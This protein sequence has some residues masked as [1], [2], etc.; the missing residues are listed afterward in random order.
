MSELRS[1]LRPSVCWFVCLLV[2]K[3]LLLTCRPEGKAV[4]WGQVLRLLS[5]VDTLVSQKACKVAVLHLLSGSVAGDEQL[6]ELFPSLLSLLVPPTDHSIQQQQCS[7]LVGTILQSL[8]D[9]V[10]RVNA[11]IETAMKGALEAQTFFIFFSILV[12]L[13]TRIFP[14][15]CLRLVKAACQRLSS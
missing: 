8:C 5:L 15:W 12:S 14:W 4:C 11:N 7:E 3:G 6:A 13:F 1:L 2:L 9:Q 10:R